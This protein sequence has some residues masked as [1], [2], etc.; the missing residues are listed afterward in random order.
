[1]PESIEAINEDFLVKVCRRTVGQLQFG[2]IGPL[3]DL[4]V[5]CRCCTGG[6]SDL[7]LVMLVIF[8]RIKSDVPDIA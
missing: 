6:R 4:G 2:V 3:I 1:M 7:A 5:T 8:C